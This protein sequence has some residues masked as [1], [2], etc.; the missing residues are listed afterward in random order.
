MSNKY[1]KV[2]ESIENNPTSFSHIVGLRE[3]AMKAASSHSFESGAILLQDYIDKYSNELIREMTSLKGVIY[4]GSF[5]IYELMYPYYNRWGGDILNPKLDIPDNSNEGLPTDDA[6][7]E[8][9]DF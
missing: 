5:S 2:F 1:V 6:D 4:T 9:I 7:I 8:E 3:A